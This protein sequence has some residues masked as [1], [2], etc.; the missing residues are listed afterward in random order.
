MKTKHAISLTVC[1]LILAGFPA[2]A[3][4]PPN[5]WDIS[6]IDVTKLPAASD[7]TDLTFDKDILPLF[8]AS[9]VRC[10]GEDKPKHDLRLD[11][12]GAVLKGGRE[13]KM[14]VPGDSKKSLLLAAAARIDDRI[15]MPPKR[16]PRR[17]PGGPGG[18][19]GPPPGGG[20][21]GGGPPPG[22]PPPG[23][24]GGPEGGPGGPPPGGGLGGPGGGPGGPAPKP[25]TADEVG[26]I[27]AWI[28]Q[29]AK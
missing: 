26:L 2:A 12:L 9:C 11:S 18:P 5:K 3:Q 6:K 23:A 19:G 16:G 14:V 24:P 10:H 17:G 27:R 1:G 28:D 15:A 7:K 21:D 20:P 13:G 8:K 29:G 22:G 4:N 25:L